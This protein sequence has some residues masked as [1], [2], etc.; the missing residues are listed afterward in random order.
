MTFQADNHLLRDL[1]RV[2][3][4]TGEDYKAV[5]EEALREAA[6]DIRHPR[7][8]GCV[9]QASSFTLAT[10]DLEILAAFPWM[11]ARPLPSLILASYISRKV[12][13]RKRR[14]LQPRP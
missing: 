2:C 6:A 1:R 3:E 13:E 10:S 14:L 8:N 12:M 7:E 9:R 4:L 11:K 5:L